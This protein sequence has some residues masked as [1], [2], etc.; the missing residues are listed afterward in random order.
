MDKKA[1]YQQCKLILIVSLTTVGL[2]ACTQTQETN[3]GMNTPEVTPEK[4]AHI[5]DDV[6]VGDFIVRT[7]NKREVSNLLEKD[8]PYMMVDVEIESTKDGAI[9][10]AESNGL[11]ANNESVALNPMP[12]TTDDVLDVSLS[13]VAFK[14]LDAGEKVQAHVTFNVSEAVLALEM[15]INQTDKIVIDLTTHK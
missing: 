4:I 15:N 14:K 11:R 8:D 12:L 10:K 5:N 13:L 6:K 3:N 7:S 2:G 9:F 1:F